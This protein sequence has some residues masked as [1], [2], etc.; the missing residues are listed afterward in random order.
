MALILVF[1]GGCSFESETTLPKP[2]SQPTLTQ[3]LPTNTPVLT[4]SQNGP[5]TVNL[6]IGD[7]RVS[8]AFVQNGNSV[9]ITVVNTRRGAV[10]LA[11]ESFILQVEG[12]KMVPSIVALAPADETLLS[13]EQS[14][15]PVVTF[16][17]T[18]YAFEDNNLLVSGYL[19]FH[20]DP[21]SFFASGWGM[22]PEQAAAFSDYL[23]SEVGAVPII[24]YAG[25]A[26]PDH[27]SGESDFRIE[28]INGDTP[29]EGETILI[30]VFLERLLGY[31]DFTEVEWFTF[32]VSFVAQ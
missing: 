7:K 12:D 14:G 24:L 19:E 18:G 29:T 17:G 3:L 26:Y 8:L 2:T 30:M 9:P 25:R 4:L 23:E 1:S 28:T 21:E 27:R 10:L 5:E 32:Q 22:S 16:G 31:A 6:Q 20:D 13:L 15:Q 11:P